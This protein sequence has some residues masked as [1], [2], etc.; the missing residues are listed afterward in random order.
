M[1]VEVQISDK[2][3]KDI[4]AYCELN[5]LETSTF[6]E[7][8]L[9][10]YFI[11][12]KYGSRPAIF[13]KTDKPE[14][15]VVVEKKPEPKVETKEELV[16]IEVPKEVKKELEEAPFKEV[17]NVIIEDSEKKEEKPKKRRK[18]S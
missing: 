13:E 16:E 17:V 1:L 7:D 14:E 12:E 18:L 15:T 9:K 5:Q 10:K 2:L 8:L 11:I 6:I 3:Y 4:F